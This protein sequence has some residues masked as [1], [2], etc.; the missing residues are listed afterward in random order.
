MAGVIEYKDGKV[1]ITDLKWGGAGG[2]QR[3]REVGE[4]TGRE[5]RG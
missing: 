2:C 4:R 5:E 1:Y 3:K